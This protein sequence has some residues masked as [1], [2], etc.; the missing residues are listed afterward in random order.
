MSNTPQADLDALWNWVV[1]EVK[2]ATNTPNFWR[3][4]EA[5]KPL[6]VENRELLVLGINPAQAQAAGLLNQDLNRNLIEQLLER[7]TKTRL[8][9]RVIHGDTLE[10]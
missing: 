2:K 9:I 6:T 5:T 3:A 1:T 10:D 8:R 4:L 7:A